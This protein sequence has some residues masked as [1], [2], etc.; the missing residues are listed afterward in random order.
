M[1]AAPRRLAVLGAGPKALALAAKLRVLAE[2]GFAVPELV[3][4]E[5]HDVA[6]HWR[7]RSGLTN[8]ELPLGTPPDKDVGFPYQS[9]SW[10]DHANRVVNARMQAYSWQSYLVDTHQYGDWVDRGRPAPVHGDWA[11]Y[12]EWV[13]RR[14]ADHVTLVR[15]EVTSLDI[16]D[17]RWAI[18]GRAPDGG[19]TL[20]HADGVVLTGP[21]EVRVPVQLPADPRILT[22]TDFWLHF[23]EHSRVDGRSAGIVGTGETAATVA[24]ALGR[25]NPRL[26]IEI[27]SPHAMTFSRGESYAENHV[28]TD[29]FRANWLQLTRADR[30]NFVRR[31]DRGVFSIAAKQ[32][33]DALR[34]VEIVPGTFTGVRVDALDQVLVDIEYANDRESRIY[35]M[36]IVSVGF[37][38]LAFVERLLAPAARAALLARLSP[39]G[40]ELEPLEDAIDHFLAVGG[41]TPFLHLPMLAGI[42]QG[43]GFPNL[44]CLGK[45]SDH[46]L[47]CYVP[48]ESVADID[49]P[50]LVG[51]D[52]V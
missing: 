17:G 46:I 21:G 42:G 11:L 24:A 7:A 29:P 8:G 43:P 38:H 19:A 31:T 36:V 51:A 15:C 37:D 30:R 44:S 5:Q 25:A 50:V 6:H 32:E 28:Y 47:A 22:V 20:V 26:D 23:R 18:A 45:L 27:I 40:L 48:V 2:T 3:I 49:N 39:H 1:S 10:G 34:N 9:Y 35:D 13:Y 16:A 41:L 4:L 14:V 52:R 33:L 12:L